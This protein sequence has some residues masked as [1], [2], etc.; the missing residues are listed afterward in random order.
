MKKILLVLCMA[1]LCISLTACGGGGES[2]IPEGMSEDT[3]KAGENL[4]ELV[5]DYITGDETATVA[6]EKADDLASRFT[7]DDHNT[8]ML[9]M[10]AQLI[11]SELLRPNP[12]LDSIKSE[13]D[14][15]KS[16]LGK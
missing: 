10:S 4:L 5:E 12:D 14:R 1:F 11:A 15:I 7:G 13:R 2:S 8:T 16:Y 6:S 3:Y 9:G